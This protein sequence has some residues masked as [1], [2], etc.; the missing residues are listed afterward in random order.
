VIRR[1]R[2][3]GDCDRVEAGRKEGRK[4]GELD[5]GNWCQQLDAVGLNGSGSEGVRE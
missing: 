4:G 3:S 1:A 5:E 2:L